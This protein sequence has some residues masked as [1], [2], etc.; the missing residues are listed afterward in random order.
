MVYI[1]VIENTVLPTTKIT[2][3]DFSDPI[4]W[5]L[6]LNTRIGCKNL[7]KVD[8]WGPLINTVITNTVVKLIPS[9]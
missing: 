8:K 3:I 6:W 2:S 9:W 5:S 4:I 1:F 7:L